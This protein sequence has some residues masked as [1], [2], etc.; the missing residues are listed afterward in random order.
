MS[1]PDPASRPP[2]D[3]PLDTRA[4]G[5][6]LR[7]IQIRALGAS[8]ALHVIALLL[9]P[10]LF[11]GLPE[12]FDR[13]NPTDARPPSGIEVLNL[14]ETETAADWGAFCAA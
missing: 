2:E 6:R 10:R 5:R 13:G 3:G 4:R 9:Y 14:V 7:R 8:A 1:A 11:G 12:A